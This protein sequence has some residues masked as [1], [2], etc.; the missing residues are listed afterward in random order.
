MGTNAKNL[1]ILLV[2]L[3]LLG[4]F[5]WTTALNITPPPSNAGEEIWKHYHHKQGMIKAI[6]IY[7]AIAM[8]IGSI[9]SFTFLMLTV[10]ESKKKA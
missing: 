10:R 2:I 1:I 3:C 8:N 5:F 6:F 4:L 9:I 7:L